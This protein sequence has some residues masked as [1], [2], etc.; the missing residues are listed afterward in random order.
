MSFNC[1]ANNSLCRYG[2]LQEMRQRLV[3]WRPQQRHLSTVVDSETVTMTTTTTS[4]VT[5]SSSSVGVAGTEPTLPGVRDGGGGSERNFV[6]DVENDETPGP[7][8]DEECVC[9]YDTPAQLPRYSCYMSI[10]IVC[11]N[12]PEADICSCHVTDKLAYTLKSIK[13][14]EVVILM[15]YCCI[16]S[17]YSSIRCFTDTV[18]WA[19]EEHLSCKSCC[20]NPTDSLL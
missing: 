5:S 16:S 1:Y 15:I 2:D 11:L 9:D 10:M 4:S 7:A 14:R 20:R 19:Q 8:D 17:G 6:E 13:L 3:S 18:G 12:H